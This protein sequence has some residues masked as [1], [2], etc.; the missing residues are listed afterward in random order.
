MTQNV[1]EEI[2][3]SVGLEKIPEEREGTRNVSPAFGEN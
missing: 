1:I 3:E 2:L